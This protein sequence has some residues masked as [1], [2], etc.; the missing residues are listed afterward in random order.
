MQ[1]IKAGAVHPALRRTTTAERNN[2]LKIEMNVKQFAE[3][4]NY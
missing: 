2:L 4:F 3:G 1:A